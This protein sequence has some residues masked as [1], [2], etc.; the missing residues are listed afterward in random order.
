M[1]SFSV[2]KKF[3]NNLKHTILA[4]WCDYSSKWALGVVLLV[5]NRK[6]IC[7][8]IICSMEVATD[9]PK[10]FCPLKHTWN[11]FLLPEEKGMK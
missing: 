8:P 11:A 4:Q 5:M 7:Y 2:C 10:L 1:I 3:I 6:Q 9:T